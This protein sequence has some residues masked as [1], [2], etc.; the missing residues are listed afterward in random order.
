M[1]FP[2][3]DFNRIVKHLNTEERF[4]IEREGSDLDIGESPLSV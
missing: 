2:L 3:A 4:T 1:T